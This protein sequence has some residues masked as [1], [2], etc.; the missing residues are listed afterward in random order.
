MLELNLSQLQH[1]PD[2]YDATLAPVSYCE[3]ALNYNCATLLL[4]CMYGNQ[5]QVSIKRFLKRN[6][7]D[8]WM[9]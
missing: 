9:A 4:Q 3:P 8:V 7:A 5:K 6:L 2:A 1:H